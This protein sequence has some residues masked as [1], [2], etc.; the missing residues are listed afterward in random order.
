MR[1]LAGVV[2]SSVLLV[3]SV[4]IG[5]SPVE[6]NTVV[7]VDCVNYNN[8]CYAFIS[9]GLGP[10]LRTL[11]LS[12]LTSGTA[13]VNSSCQSTYSTSTFVDNELW[14]YT[15]P[16]PNG[17]AYGS[18]SWDLEWIEYG[19]T[20][21]EINNVYHGLSFFWAR[22]YWAPTY[23]KYLYNEYVASGTPSLNTNYVV[24]TRWNSGG[25]WQILRNGVS[26]YTGIQSQ[27]A[28][29]NYQAVAAGAEMVTPWDT[30]NGSVSG[31]SKVQSGVT[32]NSWTG[33][34]FEDPNVFSVSQSSSYLDFS[35]YLAC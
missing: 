27:Q 23:G 22:Q 21:G 9:S 31:L 12:N 11:L 10:Q 7:V 30:E 16:N 13:T 1:R 25:Y 3:A 15:P 8:H 34:V 2:A 24:N 20:T 26:Q 33:Y 4:L 14:L 5:P 19:V 18:S 32:Y 29:G 35:T 17:P 6:A 28:P